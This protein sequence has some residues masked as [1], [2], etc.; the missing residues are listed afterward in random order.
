[1]WGKRIVRKYLSFGGA[2]TFPVINYTNFESNNGLNDLF[3]CT[4]LELK[5]DFPC[6]RIHFKCATQAANEF[7]PPPNRPIQVLI[8]KFSFK[9]LFFFFWEKFC[10]VHFFNNYLLHVGSA[11][12]TQYTLERFRET[13]TIFVLQKLTN[14]RDVGKNESRGEILPQAKCII[15]SNR[16]VTKK[17][18][19]K[20]ASIVQSNN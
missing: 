19:E 6:L 18:G 4:R 7:L 17:I 14:W 8:K 5:R 20:F 15:R 13:W 11:Q 3:Q 16:K 2:D 12:D 9:I 10:E 1:M